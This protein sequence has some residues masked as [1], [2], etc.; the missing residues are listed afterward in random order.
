[1]V[2]MTETQQQLLQK[3][4]K[5]LTMRLLRIKW[6]QEDPN[7]Q[8]KINAKSRE[9]YQKTS[10]AQIAS[11]TKWNKENKEKRNATKRALYAKKRLQN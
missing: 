8:N 10:E 3:Q 2:S 4:I 1:M 7:Y 9:Y 5:T 11:S 6:K